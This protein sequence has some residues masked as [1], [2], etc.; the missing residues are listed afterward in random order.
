MS[1][2]R[3]LVRLL[4]AAVPESLHDDVIGDLEELHRRR[5]RRWG[6]ALATFITV[7][8]GLA[9][10]VRH[11]MPRPG[12][13]A[14]T[15]ARW[16]ST[17]ELRL[18]LRL[19]V[20]Q[21]VMTL[22]AVVALGVGIG[23]A[24]GGVSF[25]RQ[26]LHGELP[27]EDGDRWVVIQSYDDASGRRTPVDLERFRLFRSSAPAFAYVGGAEGRTFNVVHPDG[28]V[29]QIAGAAVTPATFR[30]LPYVPLM[31]RLPVAGDGQP[32]AEPVALIRE[33][34]WE[35]RFSRSPDVLSRRLQVEDESRA[36]VG[37]LPDDAGYPSDGEV[38]IPMDEETLGAADDRSP[39]AGSRLMGILAPGATVEQSEGQLA[40]LSERVSGAG[41]GAVPM[42]HQVLPM[43]GT[44]N[45]A[46]EQLMS[47]VMLGVLG[48]VL[49]VIAANVANLIVARTSRRAPE[50][51]M[52]A[53]LGAS[54]GRLVSQLFVESLVIGLIAA[55]PGL[56]LAGAILE[57]YDRVLDEL[58]FWVD[59]GLDP[60]A[61]AVVLLL[62][63]ASAGVMGVL[64]ALRATSG[65]GAAGL[66]GAGR[67]GRLGVGRVGGVMIVT[68]VALSVA[69]L[70][71]A[72]LFGRGFESYLDPD[73]HLPDDRVLTARIAVELPPDVT[74][75]QPGDTRDVRG[76]SILSVARA[77]QAALAELPEVR[78]VAMASHLP[79]LSPYPEPV[80][81]ED[82]SDQ[83]PTPVVYQGAGTFEILEVSPL[84]GRVFD[85][86]DQ[87]DGAAPVAVVNQAFAL[88]SFGTTRVLGR[89]IRIVDYADE[90]AP[91]AWREIVGVVPNVMEVAGSTS[92]A[93]V[94]VPFTPRR[95]FSLAMAVEG[96]PLALVGQVRRAAFDLDAGLQVTEIVRLADV[97]SENRTALGA[98][99][100]ALTGIGLIT[101]LLSLAGVYAIVSLAVTQRTR[102]IGVRVA[103]GAERRAI[104]W[105]ILRRSVVL[106]GVGGVVGALAGL[107][108]SKARLFVFAVPEG[109]MGL[110]LGLVG[111]MAVA[112]TVA[113]WVPARRALRV[114]PMEALRY[115]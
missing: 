97:G 55:V 53:A 3:W 62:A 5:V 54:R 47:M 67:G 33:S 113:C 94:Y 45:S 104:L 9:L 98:M 35:R 38:W 23:L 68:E 46:Q 60:G 32:G 107:M 18:A 93:G 30:Y 58:P 91:S 114:Q 112:G 70:G 11:G 49:L 100:S 28:Q 56:V 106:V 57:V 83:V 86:R 19:V 37:V 85:E 74:A 77:L 16:I 82:R 10:A 21:P 111:L 76:D 71:V 108:V 44:V 81:F 24:G 42:R 89:R 50:L 27:F 110:F 90:D 88:E 79:R 15:G 12:R 52:R 59:L 101:L 6:R 13:R 29:E 80:A 8:E 14:K 72:V 84:L 63:L 87:E 69:L 103:L 4:S 78:A 31:G 73:F 109:G 48:S 7:A 26:A 92:A 2:P 20:R 95:F 1:A 25:W 22:T 41:R 43:T 66:E 36:I 102:E 96:D 39:V 17:V 34:L 51:S 64:P 61:V 40:D 105:S 75:G 115:D 99:S 65:Q